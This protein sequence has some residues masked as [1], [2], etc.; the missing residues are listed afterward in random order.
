[1]VGLPY[2]KAK[3]VWVQ[4]KLTSATTMLRTTTITTIGFI[5]TK[6]STCA[7]LTPTFFTTKSNFG[8]TTTIIIT[9]IIVISNTKCFKEF[10]F[11]LKF[12]TKLAKQYLNSN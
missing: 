6:F 2:L 8:S 5:I 9:T 10:T 1:M 12:L 7:K 11:Q 3:L 4:Q